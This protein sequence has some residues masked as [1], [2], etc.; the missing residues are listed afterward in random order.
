MEQGLI[1]EGG[2]TM[3]HY[4]GTG[5][6]YEL[7]GYAASQFYPIYGPYYFSGSGQGTDSGPKN[8]AGNTARSVVYDGNPQQSSG[9]FIPLILNGTPHPS[10]PYQKPL[11]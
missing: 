7:D 8:Y 1:L 4:Y 9:T 2:G 5:A 10:C 3:K 6:Y 11:R